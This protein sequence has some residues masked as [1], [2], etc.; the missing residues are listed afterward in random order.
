[1]KKYD[2]VCRDCRTPV[3]TDAWASWDVDK[4]EY[5]LENVFDMEYCYECEGETSSI[6]VEINKEKRNVYK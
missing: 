1:M 3:L 2:Y 6:E 4:Q 5:V